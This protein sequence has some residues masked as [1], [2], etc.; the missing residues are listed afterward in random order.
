L[1][2]QATLEEV[3]QRV[4]SLLSAAKN[5]ELLLVLL[6]EILLGPN[7]AIRGGGVL[8]RRLCQKEVELRRVLQEI[9]TE[10]IQTS[11]SQAK[12]AR[13]TFPRYVRVNT[14]KASLSEVVSKLRASGMEVY[15]DEHVPNLLVLSP[16]QASELY[17][18]ELVKEHKIVLQDKSSC[19]SALCLCHSLSGGDLLDACAAPGNKT[20]HLAA[21]VVEHLTDD[22]AKTSTKKG[23]TPAKVVPKQI[24]TIHALDRS[25]A[26]Y[27]AL[28][29]RMKE[30]VAVANDDHD[31]NNCACHPYV[32]VISHHQDFLQ[33]HPQSDFPTVRHILLDP[34][35]SGSGIVTLPDRWSDPN[36]KDDNH[37]NSTHPDASLA[38]E[39]S[40]TNTLV[41]SASLRLQKLSSFQLKALEHAMSF[42]LVNTIVYSTCSVHEEENEQVVETALQRHSE[43]QVAEP[44]CLQ[45]WKRRGN[46]NK[47]SK[48]RSCMIRVDP[49]HDET[50]G[51][52]VCLL[53]RKQIVNNGKLT[54]TKF[55]SSMPMNTPFQQ[56]PPG[57]EVYHGHFQLRQQSPVT[58][59]LE[60]AKKNILE[61]ASP[62]QSGKAESQIPSSDAN[63]ASKPDNPKKRAKKVA[64]KRRQSEQKVRRMKQK[65]SEQKPITTIADT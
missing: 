11:S 22:V 2:S 21:L 19:F 57:L 32:Q 3:L 31:N 17:Q 41:S 12:S 13:P 51:F 36:D 53:V 64:W 58:S 23:N 4:P 6:Y 60:S 46:E 48:K 10:T 55:K 5:H 18:H 63:I 38:N 34:S 37:D 16:H 24:P 47:T 62:S 33:V 59:R 45:S 20:S 39:T 40:G 52:F 30:L 27:E 9:Q 43:W 54:S 56:I 14:L 42:P 15:A 35:C 1:E 50:N 61:K 7:Q 29:R 44:N 65:S 28:K 25:P 26:R 8:K 49:Q